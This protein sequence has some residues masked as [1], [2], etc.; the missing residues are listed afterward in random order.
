M[1]FP[2]VSC[3][4]GVWGPASFPHFFPGKHAF[5][6]VPV[7]EVERIEQIWIPLDSTLGRDSQDRVSESKKKNLNITK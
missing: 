1:I 7:K 4:L 2:L 3:L 6:S 5:F